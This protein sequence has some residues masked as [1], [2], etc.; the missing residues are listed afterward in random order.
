MAL[1]LK[2][3]EPPTVAPAAPR[4]LYRDAYVL[5]LL[6]EERQL[7]RFIRSA[8]PFPDLEAPRRTYEVVIR[9]AERLAR[10]GLSLLTDL[11]AAP[12]RN[13]PAFEALMQPLRSRLQAPFARRATLVATAVGAMQIRRLT[14]EDGMERMVSSDEAELLSYLSGT[15]DGKPAR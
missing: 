3:G 11:R 7:V 4:E 5:M 2:S 1:V 15:G 14:K 8:Q 6:D 12:G 13:D 10:P 9:L